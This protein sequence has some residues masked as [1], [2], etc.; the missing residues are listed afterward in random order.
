MMEVHGTIE[1][2]LMSCGQMVKSYCYFLLQMMCK[3]ES[4]I[5]DHEFNCLNLVRENNLC[6]SVHCKTML[7]ERLPSIMPP[8]STNKALER[9]SIYSIADKPLDLTQLKVRSFAAPITH[10]QPSP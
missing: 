8:L 1:K 2:V 6:M 10:P 7:S 4:T 3:R 5:H 9:A